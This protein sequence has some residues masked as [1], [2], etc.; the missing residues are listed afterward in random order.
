M[1][2]PRPEARY[3][4]GRRDPR[5]VRYVLTAAALGFLALFVAVP[6][7]NVFARALARGPQTFAVLLGDADNRH[8]IRLTLLVAA[9]A[10]PLNV[11]F[12]V[13]AA[14]AIARFDFRGKALMVTLIDLPLS[15]SPVIAG[16]LFT[17]IFGLHGYLGP[18]LHARGVPVIFALPGIVLTTMFVTF[19]F[20]TRE[21]LPVME[22]LGRDDEEAATTIGAS[23]WQT[24]RH[25]TCPNI[26]WGL[27]YGTVL[28]TARA[29]GDFGAV[30]VVS[31][32]IPGQTE[33]MPL[34]I[35]RLYQEYQLE[36]AF[37]M[38]SLLALLA[39]ATLA[40]KRLLER[41]RHA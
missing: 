10:V 2:E 38:A 5:W 4:P 21:L 3:D 15:V 11:A 28:C 22:A 6:L 31:G 39:L 25:V 30:A 36:A 32:R 9:I 41:Q 27:L 19:P 12:G 20:V 18:W 8:A 17:L 23:G 35:E 37:A 14:W 29:M 7:A 16:L 33:T 40:A 26:R 1:R 34:R 13:A 24:F